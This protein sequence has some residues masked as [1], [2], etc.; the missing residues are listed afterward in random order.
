MKIMQL[1]IA[2]A[3]PL[4]FQAQDLAV[5]NILCC[6]ETGILQ[7]IRSE[8]PWQQPMKLKQAKYRL[9]QMLVRHVLTLG[10]NPMMLEL[11]AHCRFTTT[12]LPCMV[13]AR[14]LLLQCRLPWN[15]GRAGRPGSCLRGLPQ[16]GS[17]RLRSQGAR[18]RPC[19][20]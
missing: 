20:H 15:W 2:E 11:S 4:P 8:C 5:Q 6:P 7:L 16:P 19:R 18:P 10:L 12:A 3:L 9:M 17:L 13:A 14:R 1:R